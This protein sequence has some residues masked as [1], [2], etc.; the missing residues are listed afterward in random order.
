MW[1]EE[2]SYCTPLW[3][4]AHFQVKMLKNWGVRSTFWSWHVEKLRAAV[5][6]NAKKLTVSED[7][8]S[9]HVE[10]CTPLWREAHLQVK[11]LKKLTV[12]E[13]FLKFRFRCGKNCAPLWWEAHLQVKMLKNCHAWSI[14]WSSHVE[15]LRAA[16][17]RSTFA[18]QH[19]KKTNGFGALFDVPM[20]K[21]GTPLWREAHVQVKM[22]KIFVFWNSFFAVQMSRNQ[23][24]SKL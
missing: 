17:A 21:N 15:K 14:F 7:F 23:S 24:V 16:V 20:S 5:S 1:P 4:L 8:L 18:S 12:S 9:S 13:H 19:A 11:M 3:R 22:C 10:N 6:Q 2:K